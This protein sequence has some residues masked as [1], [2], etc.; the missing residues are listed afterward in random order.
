LVVPICKILMACLAFGYIPKDWL[1]VRVI[2]IPKIGRS[3]YELAKSFRPISLT[4][5]LL[6][7][8][9]KMVDLHIKD[10]P[11][12]LMQH[13]YLKD[14]STETTQ[15]DLVYKIDGSE[16]ICLGRLPQC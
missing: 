14:K 2:F 9:K 3:L 6:K 16:R 11:L 4:S 13:T 10:Y 8:M 15:H 7:T 5:F 1:K 12:N